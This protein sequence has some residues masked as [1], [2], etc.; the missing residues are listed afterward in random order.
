MVGEFSKI[1]YTSLSN[2][3]RFTLSERGPHLFHFL[4]IGVDPCLNVRNGFCLH[5]RFEQMPE[6]APQ[7]EVLFNRHTLGNVG[8]DE[9]SPAPLDQGNGLLASV[10]SSSPPAS[11]PPVHKPYTWPPQ[12]LPPAWTGGCPFRIARIVRTARSPA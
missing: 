7:L 5:R 8:V 2:I 3:Q 4:P 9:F 12:G 6:P 1:S 10:I 11:L